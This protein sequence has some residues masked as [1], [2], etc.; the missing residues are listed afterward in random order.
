M[1]RKEAKNRNPP[2]QGSVQC[3]LR[4]QAIKG[5]SSS[6]IWLAYLII[7]ELLTR[8]CPVV[9]LNFLNIAMI[10]EFNVS[11]R[12]RK[13]LRA[14]RFVQRTTSKLLQK[15]S[16]FFNIKAGSVWSSPSEDLTTRLVYSIV[17]FWPFLACLSM[18]R[19]IGCCSPFISLLIEKI[20]STLT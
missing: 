19:K 8:L 16:K 14:S 6:P 5:L 17:Y 7:N 4:K 10:R 13:K 11:I 2:F 9:F 3:S 20:K 1:R 15:P 12:R 18:T